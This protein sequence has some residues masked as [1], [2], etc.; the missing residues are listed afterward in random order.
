MDNYEIF[1]NYIFFKELFTDFS[2]INFRGGEIEGN[3]PINH[4]IITDVHPFLFQNKD[5]W[6]RI[7]ILLEGVSKS[8]IPHLFSPEKII[9]QDNKT[10]LVY[11]YIKAKTLE[12]ILEESEKSDNP[13]NFDL[14]FSIVLSIAE[15]ID[16]GS[17]IVVSGKKSFHGMLTPDNILIDY[18]GNIMLKNYGICPYIDKDNMVFMELE[19]RYG[20][21]MTPEFLRKEKIV[22]Q[23]DIYHLGFILFRILTGKYFSYS[24][25]DDLESK[26]SNLSFKFDIPSTDT[27]FLTNIINFFKKTL[28][29]DPMKRFTYIREFKDYIMNYFH[30][31]E[32]SSIT[33]N[34]AYFM[35]SLYS[36]LTAR[37]EKE[38]S[39]ELAYVIPEEKEE[40]EEV[41]EK[42]VP[43][44]KGEVVEGLFSEHLPKE[45]EPSGR[46]SF[47][48]IIVVVVV[49]ILGIAGGLYFLQSKKAEQVRKLAI[50]EQK[51]LEE[52][53]AQTE[54]EYL[55]RLKMLEQ[56]TATTEM[57][58]IAKDDE[59]KRLQEW[60]ADQEKIAR[61]KIKVAE[62]EK[63]KQEEM[64]QKKIEE[65][66]KK[67]KEEL[68]QK[69]QEE[70]ERKKKEE[71]E[72]QKQ[73]EAMK[74]PNEGDLV[75]FN[76]L[77]RNP[78]KLEGKDPKFSSYIRKKYKGQAMSVRA[79]ILIDENGK[80]SKVKIL[81]DVP[82]DIGAVVSMSI[83]SWVYS[84]AEKNRV[85]VKVWIQ[86]PMKISF[87]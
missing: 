10:L 5:T 22:S 12:Q 29:P 11:P 72:K 77:T 40:E 61:E 45:K 83:G 37:E 41:V 87:E 8:N 48:P 25:G 82:S 7:N 70:M 53:L 84:P 4:K 19:K 1:N 52:R 43:R 80:V 79:S 71:L 47:I 81:G 20:S 28:N 3:R 54:R 46:K 67:K 38:I 49:V 85:K 78:E 69:Q 18:D 6:N 23:S 75:P 2:G 57:E 9:K 65:Q 26:F 64:E 55:D 33:F 76:M 17:S 31:E 15:Q 21:W 42:A 58:Q 60:K 16:V 62:L 30:I 35:N 50:Q 66:E 32:L 56:K 74:K 86:V 36:D 34:L 14:A 44:K 51:K 24:E 63:K 39:T 68:E 27:E 73:E 13:I 59:I